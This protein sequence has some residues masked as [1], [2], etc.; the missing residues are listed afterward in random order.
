MK[1]TILERL[2][3][4]NI[5]PQR[6]NFTLMIAVKEIKDKVILT[7]EEIQKFNIIA[8]DH[9]TRWSKEGESYEVD[10]EFGNTL[11]VIIN[12]ALQEKSKTNEL[13]E[14]MISLYQKFVMSEPEA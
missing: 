11:S 4:G 12:E 3:L 9:G 2:V 14:E 7:S 5:L 8:D 1:L 13:T 6:G 10:I